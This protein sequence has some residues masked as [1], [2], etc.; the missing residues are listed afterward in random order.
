MGDTR[1]DRECVALCLGGQP[2]GFADLV[3][4]YHPALLPWLNGQLG[5]LER[6]EEAAQEVFVRAFVLL[7]KLR[8]PESFFPWILGIAGNVVNEERRARRRE[9]VSLPDLTPEKRAEAPAHDEELEQAIA[10]LAS[11][12]RDVVLLR[13]YSGL[14][15]V[16]MAERLGVSVGTVTKNLSRAYAMLRASLRSRQERGR[17]E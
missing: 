4:R 1:S 16:E 3:K 9:G 8:K 11:R 6:A 10:R 7:P 13:Y 14:S 17:R 2:E 15:C 12:Y 5:N